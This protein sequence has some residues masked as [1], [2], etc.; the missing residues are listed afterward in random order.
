MSSYVLSSTMQYAVE[1]TL[2]FTIQYIKG[3]VGCIATAKN[4]AFSKS[5]I[6]TS[7][8]LLCKKDLTATA[9]VRTVC[10][11][12]TPKPAAISFAATFPAVTAFTVTIPQQ[13]HMKQ[14]YLR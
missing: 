1:Y 12:T 3:T 5:N 11:Y 6:Y 4:N 14:H 9:Q 2:K 8:G 7:Q 10:I 13:Q